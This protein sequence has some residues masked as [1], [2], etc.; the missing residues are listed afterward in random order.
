MAVSTPA[1]T[2]LPAAC[3]TDQLVKIYALHLYC[4]QRHIATQQLFLSTVQ[5]NKAFGLKSCWTEGRTSTW[6][7]LVKAKGV[8]LTLM[9]S[10]NAFTA[11]STALTADVLTAA[12]LCARAGAASARAAAV[13][14]RD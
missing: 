3:N 4:A 14:A 5:T 12:S 1:L 11:E 2:L 8:Q 9:M 13:T 7:A 6:Q 10:I